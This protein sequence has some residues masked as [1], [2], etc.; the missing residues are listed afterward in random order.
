MIENYEAKSLVRNSYAS[1]FAWTEFTLNPY[2]G[3]WHDCKYCDGRA[4][5][6]YMHDD[7]SEKIRVK[8][9]AAMLLKKFLNNKGYFLKRNFNTDLFQGEG[10]NFKKAEFILFIASGVCDPYQPVE[11]KA[12]ITRQI[13]QI[14]YDYGIPIHI[15]TKNKLVLRDL[16]L[17]KK[18]NEEG[19]AGVHL[20]IT[21]GDDDIQ[22]VFEPRASSSTSRFEVVRILR[23]ENI[24]SGIYFYPVIP[25]ISDT[26]DNMS[27]MY[28][29]AKEIDAD[30]ILSGMLT[31]KPGKNKDLFMATL[32]EHFF[33]LYRK[34][35][36]LYGNNNKYGNMN[37]NS[38]STLGLLNPFIKTFMCSFEYK[39][40]YS[41]PR[42]IP[43]G[44]VRAN[45]EFAEILAKL[46]YIRGMIEESNTESKKLNQIAYFFETYKKNIFELSKT[47]IKALPIQ[48]NIQPFLIDYF[49]NKK[50]TLLEKAEENAYMMIRNR[51]FSKQ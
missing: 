9:N 3:C 48:D 44:R 14:A 34:Y 32:K 51:Y 28:Q 50:S 33:D 24:P 27:F 7:F 2:Q 11:A 38:M 41:V 5:G 47:E 23:K 16:D 21:H 20:S 8:T 29:K 49:I 10:Y 12:K 40:P 6:Y 39:I 13:L 30:F 37:Y 26:S 19:Y 15:L 31:L 45:L 43:E 25:F 35:Q 42:Y 46:S 1:T 22:K 18:I 17:L 36:L 4:E